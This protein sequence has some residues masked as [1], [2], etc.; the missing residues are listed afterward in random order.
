M[1]SF[2]ATIELKDVTASEFEH[3]DST[4][5]SASF[6]CNRKDSINF[7]QRRNRSGE[8][9]K[10]GKNITLKDV[11]SLLINTLYKTGRKYSFTIIKDKVA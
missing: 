9:I 3:L 7:Q 1:T 2:I 11:S 5:Q 4:L 8:Y 10:R 6:V